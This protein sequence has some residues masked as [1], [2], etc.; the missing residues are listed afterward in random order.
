VRNAHSDPNA[1]G[2]SAGVEPRR[3]S[4]IPAETKSATKL[5]I[6]GADASP[7]MRAVMPTQPPLPTTHSTVFGLRVRHDTPVTIVLPLAPSANRATL[8]VLAGVEPGSVVALVDRETVI[9]RANDATIAIDEPSISRRHARIVHAG[10]GRYFVE[11]L[12]SRNGT[13]VNGAR[14]R[15][16]ALTS[17][18][19]LQLGRVTLFRFAMVD[20][21]EETLQRR[22]YESS[23]RDPLT[24]LLNRR[25]LLER[26]EQELLRSTGDAADIGMLMIDVDHFKRVN[27]AFGHLAGDQVLRALAMTLQRVLRSGDV[28]GRYGGE[29][30][31]AVVPHATKADLVLLAERIRAALDAVRVEVGGGSVA[32]T[33]S[34]GAALWSECKPAHS[35]ALVALADERMYEAKA[36]GR[37]RV[38]GGVDS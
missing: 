23:T 8:T 11:D 36:R 35:S 12:G 31:L 7:A 34:I 30:F 27:D 13:F 3:A 18:D 4:E 20:E 14:V 10:D 19:R 24:G 37:N 6:P 26:L 29:E 22:L 16:V 1:P 17:G 2:G 9:G 33:V 32:M 15:R 5:R 28:L 25:C 21:D 38:I